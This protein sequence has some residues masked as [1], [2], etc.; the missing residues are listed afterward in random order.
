M[1]ILYKS[2]CSYCNIEYGAKGYKDNIQFYRGSPDTKIKFDKY[3]NSHGI[4]RPCADEVYK[5]LKNE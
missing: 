1:R 2:V 4:C 3:L 5:E